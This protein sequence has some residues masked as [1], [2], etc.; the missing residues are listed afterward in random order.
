MTQ[1]I[2]WKLDLALGEFL[3]LI[4]FFTDVTAGRQWKRHLIGTQ[5]IYEKYWDLLIK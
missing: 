5:K 4:N 2:Y 1:N 3:W